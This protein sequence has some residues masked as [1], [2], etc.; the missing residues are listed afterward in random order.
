LDGRPSN[1]NPLRVDV[2]G[3]VVNNRC[4]HI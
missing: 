4:V 1:V 2:V 3:K